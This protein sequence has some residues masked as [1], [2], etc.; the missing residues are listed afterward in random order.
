MEC[1]GDY[2]HAHAVYTRLFFLRPQ[3]AWVRGYSTI[4][5]RTY[6]DIPPSQTDLLQ[7]EFFLPKNRRHSSIVHG[8]LS[9]HCEAS[10]W[11]GGQDW[12]VFSPGF[13]HQ[14]AQPLSR[15]SRVSL[16]IHPSVTLQ[17]WSDQLKTT[18]DDT[19]E[20]AYVSPLSF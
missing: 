4:Y 2:A 5:D 11:R 3:R 20:T 1:R 18:A 17:F 13:P 16:R 14:S 10:C 12:R 7:I 6:C 8:Q 9:F 15:G 19:L